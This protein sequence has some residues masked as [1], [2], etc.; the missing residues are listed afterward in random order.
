MMDTSL[1][2]KR[3]HRSWPEALK[4]EIVAAALLPG[5]SVR[6]PVDTADEWVLHRPRDASAARQARPIR[7][8]AGPRRRALGADDLMKLLRPGD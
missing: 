3:R 4:R 1:R 6:F 7:R 2:V 5:A 8:W